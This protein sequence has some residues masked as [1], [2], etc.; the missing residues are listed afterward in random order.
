[1]I[2]VI[3]AGDETFGDPSS[4][5]RLAFAIK[6]KD[7][8]IMDIATC[9][10]ARGFAMGLY[11]SF[12]DIFMTFGCGGAQALTGHSAYTIVRQKANIFIGHVRDIRATRYG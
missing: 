2:S 1:M 5:A 9:A 4:Y 3:G 11:T 8:G 10:Q 12:G 6:A 7:N